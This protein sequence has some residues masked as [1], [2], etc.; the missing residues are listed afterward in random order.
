MMTKHAWIL[1][2]SV[3]LAFTH[4]ACLSGQIEDSDAPRSDADALRLSDAVNQEVTLISRLSGLALDVSGGSKDNGAALIQWSAHGGDNQT[5]VVSSVSNGQMVITSKAS[6]KVASLADKSGAEGS[7]VVQS[8]PGTPPDA[9][10][11]WQFTAVGGGFF[12]IQNLGTKKF[13]GLEGDGRASG[14]HAVLTSQI[15]SKSHWKLALRSGGS[16]STSVAT[17]GGGTTATST[18]VATTGGG[19]TATG[20]S[21]AT[22]GGGTTATGTSVATTG[23]GTSSDPEQLCVDTINQYRKTLGLPAYQRWTDKEQCADNQSL[24]DSQSGKAHGAFGQC[25]E[26]AQNECPGWGGPAEKMITGCLKMMWAE[27]PGDFN[28]GHGHYINMSSTNYTKVACGF[29]TLANGSVW[30]VQDFQ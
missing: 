6:G 8:A 2:I 24:Q 29:H 5:W 13:L 25:S 1:A 27:G 14:A 4:V 7:N 28:S 17:T 23:G 3:S 30:A 9:T 19:T 10:Q 16:T 26:W 18:S 22:T 15:T 12:K 20:T 21:V 11:L